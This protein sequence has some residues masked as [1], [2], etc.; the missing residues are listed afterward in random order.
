MMTD[1]EL[2]EFCWPGIDPSSP[3]A[4]AFIAGLTSEKRAVFERLDDLCGE[5]SLWQAGLGPK[6]TDAIICGPRQIRRAGKEA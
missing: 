2:L 6:P 4:V 1:A 3:E 5:I